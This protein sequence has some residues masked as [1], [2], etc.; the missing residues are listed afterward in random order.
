MERRDYVRVTGGLATLSMVSLAGCLGD[1]DDDDDEPDEFDPSAVP[2]YE[3]LVHPNEITDEFNHYRAR[4]TNPAAISEFADALNEEA[5]DRY[6]NAWL[7]WE[8]GDP[9]ATDVSRITSAR[10]SYLPE[11]TDER[12]I[13][14]FVVADHDLDEEGVTTAVTEAGFESAGEYSGFHLFERSDRTETRA[15]GDGFLLSTVRTPADVTDSDAVDMLE[16]LIDCY[17]GNADRYLDEREEVQNVLEAL[18]TEHSYLFDDY[19]AQTQTRGVDGVFEGSIARGS[20]G[21]LGDEVLTG[22]HVEEFVEGQDI[23]QPAIEEYLENAALFNNDN[24]DLDW[25]I[26]GPQLHIDWTTDLDLVN[27]V[28]LI[29][30]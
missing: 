2:A 25:D 6:T 4:S 14:R 28:Q 1:S 9:T 13:L 5:Y 8:A 15:L 23:Q 22:K 24:D 21:L 7:T 18:E 3:W 17:E 29:R 30:P 16:T 20:S 26:V 10:G 27:E 19:P 12:E 11:G